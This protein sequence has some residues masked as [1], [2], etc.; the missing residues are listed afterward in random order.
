M[1]RKAA[2][3][4]GGVAEGV[5]QLAADAAHTDLGSMHSSSSGLLLY[6]MLHQPPLV[7]QC[8]GGVVQPLGAEGAQN[9]TKWWTLTYAKFLEHGRR[10]QGP[11]I[12]KFVEVARRD[13]APT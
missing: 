9:L 5:G 1:K 7:V 2:S 8:E 4:A 10:K 3:H 6:H 13:D 12:T 11:Y